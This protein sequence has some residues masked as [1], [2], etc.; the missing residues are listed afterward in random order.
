MV[1]TTLVQVIDGLKYEARCLQTAISIIQAG[2]E[3]PDYARSELDLTEH[4]ERLFNILEFCGY[5]NK[6]RG[7]NGQEEEQRFL[8]Q[9]ELSYLGGDTEALRRMFQEAQ[10][11]SSNPGQY[12]NPKRVN[13]DLYNTRTGEFITDSKA[14]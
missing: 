11:I 8:I 1:N 14:I 6:K 5:Q 10:N 12:L 9:E 13:G 2:K 7:I 4:T 3:N